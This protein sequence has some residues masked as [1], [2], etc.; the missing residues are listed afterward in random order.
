MKKVQVSTVR[1]TANVEVIY[2]NANLISKTIKADN[3][4]TRLLAEANRYGA[5]NEEYKVDEDGDPLHDE[6]GKPIPNIVDGKQVVSYN[7]F[8]LD[9]A[10]VRE[11]AEVVAPFLTELVEAFEA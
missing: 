7:C 8:Q 11:L 4:L 1:Q 3:V 2:V 9:A 5:I 10:D 6:N